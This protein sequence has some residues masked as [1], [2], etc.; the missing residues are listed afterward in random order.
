[1]TERMLRKMRKNFNTI[2]EST[3]EQTVVQTPF[4]G[5]QF[6]EESN[7]DKL[8]LEEEKKEVLEEDEE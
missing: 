3:K 7:F 6:T 8:V 2:N 1:M 4:Y 5:V